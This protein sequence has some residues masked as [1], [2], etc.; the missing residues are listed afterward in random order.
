MTNFSESNEGKRFLAPQVD[1]VNIWLGMLR[2]M[3]SKA[4]LTQ[5]IA[6]IRSGI[7][8]AEQVASKLRTLP[9]YASRVTV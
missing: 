1:T 5:W 6:D 8:V 9:A 3:P 7:K 4:E 2:T